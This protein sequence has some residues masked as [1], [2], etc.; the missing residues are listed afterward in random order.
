MAQSTTKYAG[1]SVARAE[2]VPE[3]RFRVADYAVILKPN[4]MSLVVFTALVGLFLAPGNIDVLTAF[5][6]IT[7][8]ALGAGGAGAVNMWYDRDI[9]RTMARTSAR[10]IPAGR[11]NPR[12]ALLFGSVLAVASIGAMAVFVNV[13]AAALLAATFVYYVLIYTVWLK[14]RTP[15]NIVIGGASGALP[16]VVG[17]AAVTGGVDAGALA[18]F[19]IIF[20]WTPPHSWALALFRRDDY[21]RARVP[22]LP[23]VAGDRA[24]RNQILVY[25]LLLVPASL[26]PVAI[27]LSGVLYGVAAS[28]L[29]CL[30]VRHAVRVWRDETD[31][32]A[33]PMFGFSILYLFLI[34][35]F[36]LADTLV[37]ISY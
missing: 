2:E 7:C 36:L 11:M 17:W 26:A 37:P 10:P 18:L 28:V 8:I 25:S 3:Y 9:D 16:P 21:A 32:S 30:F 34:F 1:T 24:T 14:R 12:A 35:A 31:A 19:A 22:M 13:V 29:G 15:Q 5:V 20:L 33:R 4:V 23:V 27:G 6:A